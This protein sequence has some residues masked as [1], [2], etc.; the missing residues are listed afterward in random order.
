ML[1]YHVLKCNRKVVPL[2]NGNKKYIIGFKK[3]SDAKYVLS[4]IN[5]NATIILEVCKD[6]NNLLIENLNPC[7]NPTCLYISSI[8]F[9]ELLYQSFLYNYNII[10]PYDFPASHVI[11]Y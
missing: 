8:R 3:K 4:N 2:I 9:D 10:I 1:R 5:H 6:K 11:I 7:Y